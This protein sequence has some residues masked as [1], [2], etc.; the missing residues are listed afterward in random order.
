MQ[1]P[2]KKP[3]QVIQWEKLHEYDAPWYRPTFLWIFSLYVLR[4]LLTIVGCSAIV[5]FYKTFFTYDKIV[6]D[7]LR[8]LLTWFCMSISLIFGMLQNERAEWNVLDHISGFYRNR[9]NTTIL[10]PNGP[11]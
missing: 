9:D 7:Q 6:L 3:S 5:L 10:F 2:E 1:K 4:A 8:P 11:T